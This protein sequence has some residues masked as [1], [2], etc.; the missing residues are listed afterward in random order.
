MNATSKFLEKKDNWPLLDQVSIPDPVI[1]VQQT[2]CQSLS[3][4]AGKFPKKGGNSLG[5][6]SWTVSEIYMLPGTRSSKSEYFAC[7]SSL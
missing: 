4:K 3:L 7:F 1:F 6:H 5:R 2:G